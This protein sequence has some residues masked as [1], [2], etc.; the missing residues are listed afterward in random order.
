MRRELL[1]IIHHVSTDERELGMQYRRKSKADDFVNLKEK[2]FPK[3]PAEVQKRILDIEEKVNS[4][5]QDIGIYGI[6]HGDFHLN[7]FFVEENN[8]WVFDFDDC[9]YANYLYDVACF[10]QGCFLQ[11]YGAGKDLRKMMN[12]EI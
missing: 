12:D 7:N 1:G 3:I 6:C 10:V 2:A 11:G 5:P 9:A 8:I 4:L